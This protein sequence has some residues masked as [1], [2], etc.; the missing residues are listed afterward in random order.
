MQFFKETNKTIETC[1]GVTNGRCKIRDKILDGEINKN[2][3]ICDWECHKRECGYT[4][5]DCEIDR[6]KSTYSPLTKV[7]EKETC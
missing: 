1:I 3:V 4:G 6:I 5:G 2:A 7:I